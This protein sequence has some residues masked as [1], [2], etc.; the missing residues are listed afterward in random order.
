MACG[1]LGDSSG[2]I[3][4]ERPLPPYSRRGVE[5]RQREK[6]ELEVACRPEHREGRRRVYVAP[7][8]C[9]QGKPLREGPFK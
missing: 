2:Q 7:K 4:L 6:K 1:A 8:L 3:S 5:E 9:G